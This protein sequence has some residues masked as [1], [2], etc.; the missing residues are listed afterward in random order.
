VSEARTAIAYRNKEELEILGAEI[1]RYLGL[2]TSSINGTLVVL[3]LYLGASISS[4]MAVKST[5]PDPFNV[6]IFLCYTTG[7]YGRADRKIKKAR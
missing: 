7:P 1:T 3:Q 6:A 2:N 4:Y 5:K